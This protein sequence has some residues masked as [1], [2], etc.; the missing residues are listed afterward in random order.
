MLFAAVLLQNPADLMG[1]FD[2]GVG[3]AAVAVPAICMIGGY[4]FSGQGPRWLRAL[5]VLVLIA[6][7]PAWAL[8]ATAV[9]GP[10]MSLGTPHGAWGAVL[11]W[12]LLVTFS[13]AAGLPR[14]ASSISDRA[15]RRKR[16]QSR[17]RPGAGRV[18]HDQLGHAPGTPAPH[19]PMVPMELLIDHRH[20]GRGYGREAV[21]QVADLV[22]AHGARELLTSYLPE[23]G[24]P[25]GFYQRLGFTYRGRSDVNGEVIVKLALTWI[26]LGGTP[27]AK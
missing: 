1:G 11:F 15:E 27:S 8:N 4:G 18:C 24:G 22:R 23:T 17:A 9:E 10:S 3:L 16:G 21:R 13:I 12:S 25:A 2:G 14:R 5:G 19:R 26:T 20:Q 7:V 6:S